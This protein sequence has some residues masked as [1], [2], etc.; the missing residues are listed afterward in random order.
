MASDPNAETRQ[1]AALSLR[2]LNDPAAIP[3]LDKAVNDSAKRVRLTAIQA[4]GTM[5]ATAAVSTLTSRRAGQKD[6]D[7]RRTAFYCTG[8]R[9]PIR[10]QQLAVYQQFKDALTP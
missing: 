3:A 4:L 1:A 7:I 8:A 2:F 9:L 5:R 6:S 10:R